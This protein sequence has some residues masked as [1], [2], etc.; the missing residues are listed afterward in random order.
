MF[1]QFNQYNIQFNI[2]F[3]FY[4]KKNEN[5]LKK[6]HAVR[7]NAIT[8][9]IILNNLFANNFTNANLLTNNTIVSTHNQNPSW[10][11]SSTNSCARCMLLRNYNTILNQTILSCHQNLLTIQQFSDVLNNTVITPNLNNVKQ[12]KTDN[13]KPINPRQ[14]QKKQ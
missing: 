11:L 10:T 8:S 3:F 12:K 4:P 5:I 9:V 1:N 2:Q 14:K 7:C 13:W 6:I